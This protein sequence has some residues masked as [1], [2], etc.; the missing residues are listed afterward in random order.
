MDMD[1]D[2]TNT[3]GYRLVRRSAQELLAEAH[4]LQQLIAQ[5]DEAIAALAQDPTASATLST[6]GGSQSYTRANLADLIS[7]RDRLAAQRADLIAAALP[8]AADTRFIS[9][10][11]MTVR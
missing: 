5:A 8:A 11:W 3:A 2:Q 1:T 9:S 4:R 6:A 10:R 7:V